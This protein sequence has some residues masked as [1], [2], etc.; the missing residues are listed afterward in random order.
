[1][2]N[3]GKKLV[4]FTAGFPFG[5]AE[6]FLETEIRYLCEAFDTVLIV[7]KERRGPMRN[8]P[9][10]AVVDDSFHFSQ[11]KTLL[12]RSKIILR[13]LISENFYKEALAHRE[14]LYKPSYLRVLMSFIDASLQMRSWIG[15]N[16]DK[17]LIDAKGTVFYTYWLGDLTLGLATAGNDLFRR[18]I[19]SRAHG[20][21]LYE[22]RSVPP[23]LP[24]RKMIFKNISRVYAVSIDGKSYLSRKYPDC[25][26]IIG[27]SRLGVDDPGFDA[28][29][30]RDGVFRILS[31]SFAVRVKRIDLIIRGIAELAVRDPMRKIEWTHMGDGPL[32]LEL[33]K[34]AREIFPPNVLFRF[35]GLLE[36]RQVIE[37]YRDNMADVFLNVSG[38]EGIPV[39]VM[40]A[41]SCGIPVIA[42]PVGGVPEI[43]DNENGLLLGADPAPADVADA[44]WVFMA[45]QVD[46][47]DKKERSKETWRSQFDAKK[48][49][50]EFAM[51]LLELLESQNVLN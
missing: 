51:E 26:D 21:D 7:P 25:R 39:S 44:L 16:T 8:V 24:C 34:L 38:S 45:G 27:V 15:E 14:A 48:N 41:Q 43:V 36:N 6:Q 30:S 50:T 49:Y 5:S 46:V 40:E 47:K 13:S 33:E 23:Y 22:E 12:Y 11:P 3:A 10:N 35:T 29:P 37:F 1:M 42:T 2:K 20:I 28:K 4:L 31:C 32:R 9:S 19:V 17:R 18:K